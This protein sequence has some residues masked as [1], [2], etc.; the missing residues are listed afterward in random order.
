M[1]PLKASF[2]RKV[3]S[4][5]PTYSYTDGRSLNQAAVIINIPRLASAALEELVS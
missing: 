1:R 3:R 5:M 2:R 4:S